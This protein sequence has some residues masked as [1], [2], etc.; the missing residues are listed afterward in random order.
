[1]LKLLLNEGKSNIG[2]FEQT[3]KEGNRQGSWEEDVEANCVAG[4]GEGS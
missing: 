4:S 2:G 1:M 3:V